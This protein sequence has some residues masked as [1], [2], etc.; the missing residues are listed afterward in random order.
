MTDFFIWKL[1]LRKSPKM[2]SWENN[3]VK[4][5]VHG[6]KEREWE[7]ERENIRLCEEIITEIILEVKAR[8][9]VL[10]GHSENLSG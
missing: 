5:F 2:Q 8:L 7:R 3:I 6:K 9:L 1:L 4:V 10:K